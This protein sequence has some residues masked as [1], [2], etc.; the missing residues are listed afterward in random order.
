MGHRNNLEKNSSVYITTPIYYVNDVPH[1]GHAYTT[2]ACDTAARFYSLVGQEVVFLTGTDE[3]GQKVEKAAAQKGVSPKQFVDEVSEAFRSLTSLMD[4]KNTDFI[5]TTETRHIQAAQA[6]WSQLV[7]RGFIYLGDYSGWYAVRDEA[8][9]SEKELVNGKAPTGAD[10][11]WIT[12][13]SYFFRLSAFQEKLLAYYTEN[14]TFIMPESRRNEVMRFVEGG[15]TDLS[16]SRTSFRWGVPV[17]GN[18]THVI[19][20]WLDALTNY[21]TALGYPDTDSPLFQKHWKNAVHVVGKD[22][23]RFHAVYW[24]AFL[25][26]ADL[27]LPKQI[28]VHGWWTNEGVKISKSLGNTI[29]PV[30]LIAEFGIDAVRYFLL[31]EVPFGQDGDFSKTA[32]VNRYNSDL[33]NA[34][35]NLV[36]RVL[37]FVYKQ[38]DG[39]IPTPG[40]FAACDTSLLDMA[41]ALPSKVIELMDRFSFNRYA[42]TL[43]QFIAEANRYVDEQKPWGLKTT[44]RPRM[45]TVLYVLMEVIRK[46]ALLTQPLLPVA[47]DK[48]LS[49]L[50]IAP[51]KRTFAQFNDGLVPGTPISEPAGVFPRLGMLRCS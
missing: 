23:L 8:F 41:N 7:D 38:N 25:M 26:A 2:L 19:Y 21:I 14:P 29:D 44:D 45:M 11:E 49:Q 50:N 39:Q 16:V 13:P 20:V 1:I 43:W 37:S 47:S 36:Q 18:E 17:P 28:V 42:E 31:R 24:P 22:I 48:I 12:E 4:I 3:H 34:Y 40:A 15:L 35:G 32:L 10:V 5:R 51:D 46:T 30:A 33:A 6:L 9:Y 27:P